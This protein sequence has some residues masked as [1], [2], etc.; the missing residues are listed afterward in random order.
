MRGYGDD[1]AGHEDLNDIAVQSLFTARVSNLLRR[2]GIETAAQLLCYSATDLR[3]AADVGTKTLAQINVGLA[4]HGLAL[5][6]D[7]SPEAGPTLVEQHRRLL[8]RNQQAVAALERALADPQISPSIRTAVGE[9]VSLLSMPRTH[10][11]LTLLR[12][13]G[14]S[15]AA[16]TEKDGER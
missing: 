11:Q 12:Q 8:V 6:T 2:A 1:V 5:V 13:T 10:E 7:P 9:A 15:P 14:I 3:R 16:R 4:E